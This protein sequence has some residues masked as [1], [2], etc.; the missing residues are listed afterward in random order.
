MR[1]F[2]G[3]CAIAALGALLVA[4]SGGIVPGFIIPGFFMLLFGFAGIVLSALL[5]A[6]NISTRTNNGPHADAD[7]TKRNIVTVTP[8][9]ADLAKSII[10][11]R[12]YPKNAAIRV[13]L[14]ADEIAGFDIR[15]DLVCVDE[16]DWI[17]DSS[18]LPI[19]VAKAIIPQIEGLTV[20]ASGGE[21]VFKREKTE[22]IDT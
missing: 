5:S 19:L 9:A 11:Q 12:G 14:A 20:D 18:G 7:C 17:G 21:Y 15:Y 2:I 22:G 4:R 10:K 3:S 13:V 8:D 6:Y 1:F 16:R